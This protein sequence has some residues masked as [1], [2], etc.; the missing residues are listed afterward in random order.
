MKIEELKRKVKEQSLGISR[1][2]K[3]TKKEFIELANA[4]FC[5]DYGMTLVFLMEEYKKSEVYNYLAS[6]LFELEQQINQLNNVQPTDEIKLVGGKSIK[7]KG[8]KDE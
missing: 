2:P 8:G 7:R 3:N 6:K 1:L 5:S 4:M